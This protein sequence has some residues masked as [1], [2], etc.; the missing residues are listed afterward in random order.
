MAEWR[1]FPGLSRFGLLS[2][3]CLAVAA[4][5][6]H[7]HHRISTSEIVKLD[8]FKTGEEVSIVD[9]DGRDRIFT[10][11]TPLTFHLQNG[12]FIQ[13]TFSVIEVDEG[14]FRGYSPKGLITVTLNDVEQVW[15]SILREDLVIGLTVLVAIGVILFIGASILFFLTAP[16]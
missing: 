8:G 16:G 14:I 12:D 2:L 9:I 11:S 3:L 4:S 1:N 10:G 15:I 7:R 13:T 6:C 5:G